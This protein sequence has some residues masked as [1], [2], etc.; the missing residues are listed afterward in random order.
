MRLVFVAVLFAACATAPPPPRRVRRLRPRRP[1]AAAPVA[2]PVAAPIAF[3]TP[4]PSLAQA[5][6]TAAGRPGAADEARCQASRAHNAALIDRVAARPACAGA[7][8]A[9]RES[10]GSCA[11]GPEGAWAAELTDATPD[12]DG[13][14]CRVAVRWRPRLLRAGDAVTDSGDE[15][16]RVGRAFT[17]M[18][19]GADVQA[20]TRLDLEVADLDADQLPELAVT[21]TAVNHGLG[22][23]EVAIEVYSAAGARVTVFDPTRAMQPI[24]VVDADQDGRFDLVIPAPYTWEEGAECGRTVIREPVTLLAHS[25][26]RG[27]FSTTDAVAAQHL[28]AVCPSPGAVAL[29]PT[30]G[31]GVDPAGVGVICRRLWGASPAEALAPLRCER[32]RAEPSTLC[33]NTIHALAPLEPGECPAHYE[34]WARVAPPLTLR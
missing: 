11:F 22:R 3:T 17:V 23:Q 6:R 9:L 7:A 4:A 18:A 12:E 1:V 15:P 24:E 29:P 13:E 30:V 2:V 26:S 5:P 33:A 31:E 21:A 10:F 14:L 25:L 27:G 20:Y 34:A 19:A 8:A 28:R 16:G 32:F